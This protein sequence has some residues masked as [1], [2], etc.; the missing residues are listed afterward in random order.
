MA[1]GD[2]KERLQKV[3]ADAGLGSRREIEDWI[4]AGRIQVNGRVAELGLRVG[5][6]E[7]I[8]LDG[9]PVGIRRSTRSKR[10]VVLY[11]KPEGE[12]V[13]RH[14][15]QGRPSVFARLPQLAQG[16]WISIGR[17]D[18]NSAGLLLFT[19][20]GQLANR[21]MHP[22]Q[23]IEREYAVRVLGEVTDDMLQRLVNGVELDDGPARCE[24][25]TRSGGEGANRWY[26]LVIM[27]GRKR[28]V[29]RLW[30]AVGVR[31]SRLKRVRFG[32]IILNSAVKAG[33]WRELDASEQAGLLRAAD[34]A[35]DRPWGRLLAEERRRRGLGRSS[36]KRV[37][38]GGAQP[39]PGVGKGRRR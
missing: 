7:K 10:Y 23:Q 17:L 36:S 3:L 37:R 35:N 18:I 33:Q 13:T 24:E 11:N 28:E 29:R 1:D 16:R 32:P 6:N 19:S 12:V 34:L 9:R 15:P 4:R 5:D 21:L 8:L 39:A 2:L 22:R 20:D 25:I 27:E 30:E 26:H 31:V 14:D 38:S